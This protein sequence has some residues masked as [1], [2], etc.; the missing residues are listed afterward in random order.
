MTNLCVI[1][2]YFWTVGNRGYGGRKWGAIVLL[3]GSVSIVFTKDIGIQAGGRVI[4]SI[5][6]PK[7]YQNAKAGDCECE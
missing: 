7:G 6:N 1:L 2:E 5:E 3:V 4:G